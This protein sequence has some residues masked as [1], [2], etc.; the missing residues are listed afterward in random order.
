MDGKYKCKGCKD[1]LP[2]SE[3]ISSRTPSKIT[4][5]C[6]SCRKI[7]SERTARSYAKKRSLVQKKPS[8][9]SSKK[10]RPKKSSPFNYS[11]DCQESTSSSCTT[12]SRA[13]RKPLC[14]QDFATLLHEQD[15]MCAGPDKTISPSNF[16]LNNE[17]GR[18]ITT[19]N[20]IDHIEKYAEGGSS[21]I[22][23][24]QLLCPNCHAY[25]C[26]LERKSENGQSMTKEERETLKFFT[27]P[28]E[29]YN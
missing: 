25:K 7:D 5:K 29:I 3:F 28:K 21:K 8:S 2:R 4:L 26:S 12:I 24:L 6:T 23:N 13:P 11:S 17:F 22:A 19:L 15:Y 16:C 14:N 1:Y 9:S 18:K 20:N 27:K 10:I